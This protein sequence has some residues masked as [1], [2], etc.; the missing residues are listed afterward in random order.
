MITYEAKLLP[1]LM[2]ELP[3]GPTILYGDGT[4][5]FSPTPP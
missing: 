4:G 1:D 2:V 3:T 5:G